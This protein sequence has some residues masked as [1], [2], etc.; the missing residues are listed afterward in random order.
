M[1]EE[2]C[3]GRTEESKRD[4]VGERKLGLEVRDGPPPVI[5]EKDTRLQEEVDKLYSEKREAGLVGLVGGLE[6]VIINV[7]PHLLLAA[8]EE[9]LRSTGHDFADAFRDPQ[10]TTVVLR[11]EG[12]CDL[13]L[14]ARLRGKN[15]FQRRN[16]QPKS[17]HLPN[18]RLETF[19]FR[20]RD[21]EEF[22]SIQRSRGVSFLTDGVIDGAEA[23]FIQTAPSVYT[24]NSIG[25]ITT[26]GKGGSYRTP[27]SKT[28]DL[29]LVKP[30]RGYLS[31]INHLDH[32]ATRVRAEDR[33]AAML[34]FISLTDYAFDFAIYV[35]DLNSITSVARER[36]SDFAM[37]FT[38]GISPSRSL[39]VL[40]P[41]EKFVFNYGPRVHHIAFQTEDIEETCA[42]LV[43]DGTEFLIGLVGSQEE[44]LKQTF[45]Q[46]S[47]NTL[48]VNEYIHR[49]GD[50]DGFFTKKNV[51]LLTEATDRQ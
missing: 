13:I 19:V 15:P 16:L 31:K 3:S 8:S 42:A 50:F 37:V 20:T 33:D 7:E 48:L 34:E 4:V 12:S 6:A 26:H 17:R 25:F 40:G 51:T 14:R 21:I 44:G 10:Y 35:K 39:E 41:T 47:A 45:T 5:D 22:V 27:E 1:A 28:V 23:S 24:G 11:K 2:N 18:T 36:G 43:E 32:G 38:S 30:D 29:E 49:Y 46:P 9:L